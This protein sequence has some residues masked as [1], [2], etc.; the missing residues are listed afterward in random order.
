V[1]DSVLFFNT[2]VRAGAHLNRVV[3]DVNTSF[4]CRAKVGVASAG[5]PNLVTV[6]GWNNHIP[7]DMV[8]G[9]GCTVAPGIAEDKWPEQGLK[10]LEELQ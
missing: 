5:G 1:S 6:I 9:S 2:V 3:S 10:D 8:I 4:G 7:E